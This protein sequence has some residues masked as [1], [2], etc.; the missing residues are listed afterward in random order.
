M[1]HGKTRPGAPIF[2]EASELK[3]RFN[4]SY[5]MPDKKFF[6]LGL[7]AKR[8]QIKSIS[9]EPRPLAGMRHR[10]PRT[11]RAGRTEAPQKRHVQWLGRAHFIVGASC[12]QTP[13]L[14]PRFHLASRNT[15]VSQWE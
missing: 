13:E 8:K 7:D 3:K 14:P 9:S 6:A 4:D 12:V 10:R 5:W 2:R 15:E 1:V 11:R